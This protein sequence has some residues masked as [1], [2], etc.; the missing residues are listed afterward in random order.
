MSLVSLVLASLLL[1]IGLGSISAAQQQNQPGGDA[2]AVVTAFEVAR[3]R[4]DVDAALATFAADATIT[5]RAASFSGSDEIRRFIETAASR[6]RF[7]TVS[8]RRIEGNRVVWSERN[9]NQNSNLPET[10]VEAVVVEGKIKSLVYSGLAPGQ[11]TQA[12]PDA[13]GQLPAVFG[14][15]SVLFVLFAGVLGSSIRFRR[16]QSA[17]SSLQGRMLRDLRGWSHAEGPAKLKA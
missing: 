9:V 17:P 8:N 3:N 5:Q 1:T 2:S 11:R 4:G 7:P 12:G 14:M 16:S 15:G 13:R 10:S 6:G